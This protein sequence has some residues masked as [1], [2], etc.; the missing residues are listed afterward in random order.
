[1]SSPPNSRYGLIFQRWSKVASAFVMLVGALVLI[2]WFT[3][4]V[5]L[6]RLLPGSIVMKAN[7]RRAFLLAGLALW[8]LHCEGDRRGGW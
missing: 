4:N 2:G 1:M 7:T 5:P 6:K 3:D 8:L